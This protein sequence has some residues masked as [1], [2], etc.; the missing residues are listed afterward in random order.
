MDEKLSVAATHSWLDSLGAAVSFTCAIHCSVFP[1]LIGV[2]PLLGLDFLLDREVEIIFLTAAVVLGVSSFGVG[3]RAHR[4]MY[5]FFFLLGALAL[6]VMGRQLGDERL[7]LPLVVCGSLVL[8][9]GHFVN[10]RL[11]RLCSDCDPRRDSK[12]SKGAAESFRN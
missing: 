10:R 2:L 3:F 1:F 8:A 6:I 12:L 4:R 11:C 7:E 9:A 5:V